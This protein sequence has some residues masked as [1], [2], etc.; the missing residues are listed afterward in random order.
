MEE[1]MGPTHVLRRRHRAWPRTGVAIVGWT[2]CSSV[3]LI[4]LYLLYCALAR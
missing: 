3:L 4:W 1:A 2:I